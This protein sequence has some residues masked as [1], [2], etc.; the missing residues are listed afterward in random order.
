VLWL[1]GSVAT[2]W[3]GITGHAVLLVPVGAIGFAASLG[4]WFQWAPAKRILM[5]WFVIVAGLAVFQMITKGVSIRHLLR[6][7]AVSYFVHTL[8]QWETE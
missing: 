5:V 7:V 3:L 4:I 8:A 6:I 1:V 2:V